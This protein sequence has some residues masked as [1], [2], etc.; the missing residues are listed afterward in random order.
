MAFLERLYPMIDLLKTQEQ[1]FLYHFWVNPPNEQKI[2]NTEKELGYELAPEIVDFYKECNGFQL[3]WVHKQNKYIKDTSKWKETHQSLSESTIF[4]N[5]ATDGVINI[6][7]IEDA[8]LTNWY[9]H[10]YFDFTIE[11]AEEQDFL[12]KTYIEPDFSKRIKPFDLYSEYHDMAFFLDGSSNP[13]IIMGD[14][15]QA[16][17]TDSYVI[18]FQAYLD[19]LLYS[20]GTCH[21]RSNFFGKY[22]GFEKPPVTSETIKLLPPLDLKNYDTERNELKLPFEKQFWSD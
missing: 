15:Y 9:N 13:P 3:V 6:S 19:F 11:N 18:Y 2:L 14:D 8:F 20:Y 12:G 22:H 16:C 17:Y 4:Y 1:V 5:M 21:A 10:I 7:S